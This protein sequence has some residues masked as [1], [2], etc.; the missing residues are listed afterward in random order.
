MYYKHPPKRKS[1]FA[2]ALALCLSTFLVGTSLSV[3]AENFYQLKWPVSS[4]KATPGASDARAHL[5]T[6]L[7]DFD[8]V[9][10]P[11][12]LGSSKEQSVRLFNYGTAALSFSGGP[13]LTG[14]TAFSSVTNCGATLEPNAYCDT[15]VVFSPEGFEAQQGSLT[16]ETSVGAKSVAI[17]GVAIVQ[18]PTLESIAPSALLAGDQG[19]V[20]IFKG[21]RLVN[22]DY[23][24][25]KNGTD[26]QGVTVTRLSNTQVTLPSAALSESSAS[27]SLRSNHGSTQAVAVTVFPVQTVS[28]MAAKLSNATFDVT[29][30]AAVTARL[31]NVSQAKLWKDGSVVANGGAAW[32]ATNSL[33]T[34]TVS[35][36]SPDVNTYDLELLDSSAK[37]VAFQSQALQVSAQGGQLTAN[38][39]NSFGTLANGSSA[40]RVFTFKN[41]SGAVLSG[42][43][44]ELRGTFN[45]LSIV[46]NTCGSQAAPATL[47]TNS[48]CSVTVRWAPS[49]NSTL[50]ASLAIVSPVLTLPNPISLTGASVA[51]GGMS[52]ISATYPYN[53][54]GYTNNILGS[55]RTICNGKTGCSFDPYVLIGSKDPRDGFVKSMLVT[56]TCGHTGS[57]VHTYFH[58]G[59]AGTHLNYLT[60]V[61]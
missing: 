28:P 53:L 6:N 3:K 24:L 25:Q 50:S 8:I 11:T 16:F 30:N 13:S 36:T 55:V 14:A 61:R 52:V 32:N 33:L 42:V 27:Y 31:A 44:P 38:T 34:V 59:E 12:Y 35:G 2:R 22:T 56:F 18:P 60:C 7:I 39:S 20:V 1:T 4:L 57:T 54:P 37:R 19:T 41:V 49:S 43:Y 26:L 51:P 15:A 10:F 45:G 46:A 29:A 23:I 21:A 40:D 17:K 48:T 47:A 5:S 58:P 9:K